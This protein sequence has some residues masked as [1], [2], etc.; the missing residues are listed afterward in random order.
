VEWSCYLQVQKSSITHASAPIILTLHPMK[1]VEIPYI[2]TTLDLHTSPGPN[3]LF[4][5]IAPLNPLHLDVLAPKRFF[6]RYMTPIRPKHM[7]LFACNYLVFAIP[8]RLV[9]H[10]LSGAY[11]FSPVF[12]IPPFR[13][14]LVIEIRPRLIFCCTKR[15]ENV[16]VCQPAHQPE[17][18]AKSRI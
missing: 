12:S 16:D 6:R 1:Q 5:A 2:C 17:R 3:Y 10:V 13:N 15:T 7:L 14:Y 8:P 4:H 9:H 18:T 11:F